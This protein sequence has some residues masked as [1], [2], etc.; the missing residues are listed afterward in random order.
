MSKIP[1]LVFCGWGHSA[2][3]PFYYTVALDNKGFHGGHQKETGYLNELENYE[4]YNQPMWTYTSDPYERLLGEDSPN[5]PP[6]LNRHSPYTRHSEEFI[7]DWIAEPPSIE[8]Y[9]EYYKIHYEN[10]KHD[11]YGV[12]DFANGNCWLRKPFLDK[13]IPILQSHFDIKCV[14]VCRDPVRRSYS[15]FSAKFTGNC[16]SSRWYKKGE[17]YPGLKMDDD[18]KTMK[19]LFKGELKKSCTRF[20]VEFYRK[21]KRYVPTLQLVMEEFWEPSRFDEQTK[22]LS[23]FLEFPITKIHENA[24]WPEAADKAPKYDYLKDQWG[25]VKDPITPELYQYGRNALSTVYDDWVDEFGVLPD[26]WGE[27]I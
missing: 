11:Y 3:T 5:V 17:I 4:Y 12:S 9:I 24:F 19:E 15:D 23:D 25:S 13:Y 16:S 18:Y 6:I 8:K 20:Y 26:T 2:T 27:Y 10:I 21:I 22:K 14:F 1:F 7:R